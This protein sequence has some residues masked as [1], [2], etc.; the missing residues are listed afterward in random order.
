VHGNVEID[1]RELRAEVNSAERAARLRS[2]LEE[3]LGEG[4]RHKQTESE[5]L[6]D[7]M[8]RERASSR[9]SEAPER[10]AWA[11]EPAVRDRISELMAAHYESWVSEE[12]PALGGLTPL[13][14]VRDRVGRAKVEALITQME[15]S[16]SHMDPPLGESVFARMRER[17]GLGQRS[18]PEG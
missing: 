15:R 6:E 18:R 5:S 8:S 17:L 1:G 2:I 14:A 3:S 12:I 11:D 16:G 10:P 9:A 13:E 7:A 4:I